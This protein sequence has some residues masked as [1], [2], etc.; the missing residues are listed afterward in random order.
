PTDVNIVQIALVSE[1]ASDKEIGE[2]ADQ[3]RKDLTKVK[4][5]KNVEDWGYPEGMVRI[6]LDVE[7]MAQQHVPVN[8]VVGA[9]QAENYTI[10]GG[11]IQVGTRKFNIKSSG[12]YE[13]LDEIRNTVVSTDGKS[14]IRLGDIAE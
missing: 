8:Q 12:D 2:Y 13:S 7:K 10:P 6:L 9:L 1:T 4:D 11:S 3:L 14:I 5:L